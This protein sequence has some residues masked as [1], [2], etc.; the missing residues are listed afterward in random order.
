MSALES[1]REHLA[2]ML[3][4][5]RQF[6]LQNMEMIMCCRLTRDEISWPE[7]LELNRERM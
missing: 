1:F 4:R 3:G 7:Q 2:R 6:F 5:S